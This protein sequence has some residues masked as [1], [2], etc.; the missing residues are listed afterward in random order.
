MSKLPV[1]IALLA[2]LVAGGLYLRV[3]QL[4]QRL[5]RL[6]GGHHGAAPAAGAMAHEAEEGIEVAVVMGRMERFHTKWWLAG[7]E[8]NAALAAFYL[9]ELEE[10]MEEVAE[11]HVVEDNG[12]DVSAN[13][14]TYGLPV[15]KEL[16]RKLKEQGVAAMHA[17]ADV[18]V[19]TCNSCHVATGHSFI[20]VQVPQGITFPGQDFRP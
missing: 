13:M 10:A 1:L 16:E 17:D 20:R 8:G 5:V 11:A 15:V 9:H 7:G 14:R 19:A 18:L 12:V 6:D 2:L 3:S 4:E